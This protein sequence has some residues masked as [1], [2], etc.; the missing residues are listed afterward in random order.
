MSK[1]GEGIDINAMIRETQ[2]MMMMM[3]KSIK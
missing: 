2:M 1:K 3:I